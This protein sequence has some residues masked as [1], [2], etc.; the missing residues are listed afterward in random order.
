MEMISRWYPDGQ[1]DKQI[2]G[3]VMRGYFHL[4][5]NSIPTTQG[6]AVIFVILI[7]LLLIFTVL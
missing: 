7:L 2:H 3:K 4:H 5:N 6:R 1:F